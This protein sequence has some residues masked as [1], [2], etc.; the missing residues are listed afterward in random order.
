MSQCTTSASGMTAGSITSS[1]LSPSIGT[2]NSLT[3]LSLTFTPNTNLVS[4][5]SVTVTFPSE[6]SVSGITQVF[7]PASSQTLSPSISGQA[8]TVSGVV[9]N[10][11]LSLTMTFIQITNPASELP[12]STF[13][14]TTSRN[15]HSMGTLSSSLTYS[16]TRATISTASLTGSSLQIGDTSTYTLQFTLGQ[17]LTSNSSIIIGLPV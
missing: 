7:I 9:V 10:L 2:V 4:T 1:S 11:G 14:I 15:S 17:P 3:Q 5:D 8:I 13:G 6:I 16:A 12:T